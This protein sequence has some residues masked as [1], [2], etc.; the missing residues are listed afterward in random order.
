M[1]ETWCNDVRPGDTDPVVIILLHLKCSDSIVSIL[2]I[3]WRFKKTS[4]K[5]ENIKCIVNIKDLIKLSSIICSEEPFELYV[6]LYWS[7]VRG[8][9]HITKRWTG[10]A[11]DFIHFLLSKGFSHPSRQ[12]VQPIPKCLKVQFLPIYLIA[13]LFGIKFIF[14]YKVQKG[15]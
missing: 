3:Q 11:E 1:T 12:N 15:S 14:W 9:F 8:T 2:K 5:T 10:Q 6:C 4:T 13:I 7:L